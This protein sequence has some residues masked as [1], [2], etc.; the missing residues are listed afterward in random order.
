M[1]C[2][3]VP[4]PICASFESISIVFWEMD[5]RFICLYACGMRRALL[6]VCLIATFGFL[7]VIGIACE[8]G[9]LSQREAFRFAAVVV[10]GR[11]TKIEHFRFV[12]TADSLRIETEPMPP[13]VNDYTLVTLRVDTY[14]KGAPTRFLKIYAVAR[15]SMCDGYRFEE[16]REYVVYVD[17]MIPEWEEVKSFAGGALIC[18]IGNCPHRV[19]AE[20]LVEEARRLGRGRRI[21]Q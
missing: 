15:P 12:K 7:P 18:E 16:G 6:L 13:R 11:V 4:P 21:V 2:R 1:L 17:P 9:E 19:I 14:W 5:R 8:C 20:S 10:R 3:E